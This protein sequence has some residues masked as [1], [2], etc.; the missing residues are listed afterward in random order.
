MIWSLT[1]PSYLFF[2]AQVQGGA[3]DAELDLSELMGGSASKGGLGSG[4]IERA[5]R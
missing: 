5:A 3:L 1:L 4:L 2:L